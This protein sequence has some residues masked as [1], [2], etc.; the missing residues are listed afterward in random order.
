MSSPCWI[1]VF[2]LFVLLS[3]CTLPQSADDDAVHLTPW[4]HPNL[5]GVWD[6][7]TLTPLERPSHMGEK[8]SLTEQE[9]AEFVA[10]VPERD[11]A[12]FATFLEDPGAAYELWDDRGTALTENHP[13]SLV[14]DPPDGKI[15]RTE[16]SQR[17][18]SERI[19]QFFVGRPDSH[20]DRAL[21]ERCLEWTPT[22]LNVAF[23]NNNI[24]IFQTMES[25]VILHKMIHD[26]RVI[27]LDSRPHL[28]DTM[29]Q[30]RGSSRGHWE[31]DTLVV[32]SKGFSHDVML[33]RLYEY[34]CHE[35]NR[36]LTVMLQGARVQ[37][38]AEA[39]SR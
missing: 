2:G 11:H 5:Q 34:A 12:L 15:P 17:Q 8:T 25:V 23:S 4:G 19:T 29:R 7:R 18:L 36:S 39:E 6:F 3:G 37:D 30:L 31:G 26:V 13:T 28:P 1:T 10:T 32:E 16:A 35:G 38:R 22:P 20:E 24:Q 27:Y 14:I 33:R 21:S 9:A